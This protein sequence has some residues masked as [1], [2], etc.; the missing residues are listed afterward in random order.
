MSGEKK[1]ENRKQKTEENALSANF[2]A[3][4]RNLQILSA[5]SVFCFLFSVFFS[6]F[7]SSVLAQTAPRVVIISCAGLTL[8]DLRNAQN[9]ALRA[10]A[11]Q[12]ADA[13]MNQASQTD[14][15]ISPI[16]LFG[17]GS[18][19]HSAEIEISR[20]NPDG[21][22]LPIDSPLADYQ[23]LLNRPDADI[24]IV[25]LRDLERAAQ[26][27][28]SDPAS[29]AAALH[30]LNL[31]VTL[32]MQSPPERPT[33]WLLFAP[34]TGGREEG[35][36]KR[37]K[38]GS[39]SSLF[40][41]PS[42][43][44]PFLASG[45]DFPP[46]LLVSAT[47]RTPGLV[48][49]RDIAPT[50]ARLL[51]LPLAEPTEGR[52]LK[53]AAIGKDGAERLERLARID[54]LA[55]LNG[56]AMWPVALGL[57]GLC[58]VWIGIGFGVKK[59]RPRWTPYFTPAFVFAQNAGAGAMLAP[60]LVPPTLPE[61]GLRIA[62]WMLALT[63]L[64]YAFARLVRL[65]PPL[66]A[67][68]LTLAL[69]IGDTMTGQNL[70]KDSLISDYALA[71]IR[72]YGVGNEYLGAALGLALAG[73]F[74]WLDAMRVPFPPTRE[75][76][77]A[78]RGLLLCWLGLTLLLGWPGLGAN[79]GSLIACGAGFGVGA[80]LLLGRRADWK[81][82]AAGALAGLLLAF[83]FSLLDARLSGGEA[84]HLGA[85]MQAAGGGRGAGY[86]AAIV[87]R[88]IAMN[89]R[90]LFSPAFLL[91][92]VVVAAVAT[93]SGR[94]FGAEWRSLLARRPWLAQS[95]KALLAA[96]IASLLFKDSGV[97]TA[98]FLTGSAWLLFAWFLFNEPKSEIN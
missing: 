68:F 88:K 52:T 6:L 55:G 46:G 38:I 96:G 90:L 14:R 62:A 36:G 79:A 98:L 57:F 67:A 44:S 97:V 7:F 34:P 75:A 59:Y 8:D 85:A 24:L 16:A 50:L 73:S 87:L 42:S 72:Y 64:C 58:A 76:R 35:R 27:G 78:R 86:P 60:L 82:G 23:A 4:P 11:E 94:I 13:M 53:V 84:S 30:R 83:G 15:E 70:L 9:S 19:V 61:Y 69:L 91:A 71:G 45:P 81:I 43:L 18:A 12:G 80:A 29:R 21:S 74:A 37:E 17:A 49:N 26:N 66:I 25:R 65:P 92:A 39:F 33:D 48:S 32:L 47:T 5:H 22:A 95:R 3:F 31:L 10:W 20:A 41:L 40:P 1:I 93:F 77:G 54:Y 51:H 63:A 2:A 28:K 56:R 89:F